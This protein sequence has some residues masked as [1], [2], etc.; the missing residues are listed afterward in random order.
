LGGGGGA[1][2]RAKRKEIKKLRNRK[3]GQVQKDMGKSLEEKERQAKEEKGGTHPKAR[4]NRRGGEECF[5]KRG[6]GGGAR[7]GGAN[8]KSK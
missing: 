8:Q 4:F 2:G 3:N 7:W 6:D 1:D 5:Q